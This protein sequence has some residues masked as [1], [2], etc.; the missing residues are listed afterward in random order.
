MTTHT[1]VNIQLRCI[2]YLV[3]C[4]MYHHFLRIIYELIIILG[5]MFSIGGLHDG[6]YRNRAIFGKIRYMNYK[7]CQ[8]KFDVT[9]FVARYSTENVMN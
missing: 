8:R 6:A 5:C 9:A 4:T 1:N 3:P 7:G 2:S